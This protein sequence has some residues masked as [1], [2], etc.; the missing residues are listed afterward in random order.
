M[1]VS[2]YWGLSAG[3]RVT[4]EC[5]RMHQ[6]PLSGSDRCVAPGSHPARGSTSVE[7]R[8]V[9]GPAFPPKPRQALLAPVSDA[10]P[11]YPRQT[12]N[13][14]VPYSPKKLG[15]FQPRQKDTRLV[16]APAPPTA[17]VGRLRSPGRF[18]ARDP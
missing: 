10:L 12:K 9:S 17:R 4:P 6:A 14:L 18:P 2:A 5:E 13:L 15:S 7:F 8:T 3:G 11:L 1:R 16:P